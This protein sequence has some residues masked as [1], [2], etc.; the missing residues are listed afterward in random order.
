MHFTVTPCHTSVRVK[1]DGS[2][3]VQA[4]GAPFEHARHQNYTVVTGR[5][6]IKFR[7]IA[8][9]LLGQCKVVHIFRLTEIQGIMQF[10]QNYQLRALG[11]KIFNCRK[12]S[13]SVSI[14]ILTECMLHYSYF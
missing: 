7:K 4:R 10:G 11:S 9:Y 6:G 2:I 1:Y 12:I 3:V 13:G 14:D 8:R 5:L